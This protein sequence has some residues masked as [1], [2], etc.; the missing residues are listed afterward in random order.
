MNSLEQ[1]KKLRIAWLPWS[2]NPIAAANLR[3]FS[4]F[5]QLVGLEYE[6]YQPGGIYDVIILNQ[7]CDLTY[8]SRFK[9]EKTKLVFEFVDSYLDVSVLEPRALFRGLAKFLFR[10][11]H[12]LEFSYHESIKQMMR[13]ADAVVCSTPE[14]KKSYESYN[15]K[16][17]NI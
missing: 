4:I 13:R 1:I 16:V 17:F 8:W 6:V 2:K 3:R 12:Y 11:H 14:Q 15:Q 7:N 5:A 10:Q 9:N